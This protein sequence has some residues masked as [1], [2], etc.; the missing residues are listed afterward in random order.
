MKIFGGSLKMYL[1]ADLFKLS[2]FM[3]PCIL[4]P[5]LFL[6]YYCGTIINLLLYTCEMCSLISIGEIWFIYVR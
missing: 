3:L 1:N 5:R 4:K 6:N 2:P